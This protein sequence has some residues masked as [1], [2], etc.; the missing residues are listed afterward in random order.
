M[1]PHISNEALG[2]TC[3]SVVRS[4]EVQLKPG[5]LQNHDFT[6]QKKEKKNKHNKKAALR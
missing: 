1:L 3:K 4:L 2:G 6:M 5:E